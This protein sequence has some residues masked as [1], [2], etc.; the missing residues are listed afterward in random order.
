[1]YASRKA[2]HKASPENRDETSCNSGYTFLTRFDISYFRFQSQRGIN[3]LLRKVLKMFIAL[4]RASNEV[5]FLM[6]TLGIV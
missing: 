1:M 2:A 4:L 3:S 6:L 5:S